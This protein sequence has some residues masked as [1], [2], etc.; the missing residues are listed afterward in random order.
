MWEW[1]PCPSDY[2]QCRKSTTKKHFAGRLPPTM[3]RPRFMAAEPIQFFNRTTGRVE[4]EQVYGEGFLRFTYGNPLGLL[5]LHALAKRA[6]FSRWY[7]WRMDRSISKSRVA[8]FIERYGLDAAEFAEPAESFR[9]FNEF[10]YRK[11]K[12]S[13]R[14][15]NPDSEVAV[16]P[17]DGRHL[18]L[19][20]LS[21]TDGFYVKGQRLDLA[22]LLGDASLA[23]EFAGGSIV[24]SRLCPVDYHR[25]HFPVVGLAEAPRLINGFLYSVSP[26]ALRRNI[27]Y[28]CQNKRSL[29]VI[30][31]PEFGR[32]AT[33]EVGATNVG[34]WDY[35]FAP[36]PVTKGQEKGF[37]RFG[38]SLTITVFAQGRAR[39]ADDL[40]ANG[41]RQREVYAK[42]G[43]AMAT[44]AERNGN[45]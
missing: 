36:G 25:F 10:F 40:I 17:A 34:S 28:L 32:V 23:R 11:L 1:V 26:I 4:T 12:P 33:L 20:D 14:P 2:W 38:G 13:A 44:A 45:R 35:T 37:F 27:R 8:C 21:K 5:A 18:G 41:A 15:V 3:I 42:I 24:F 16:F 43:D 9:S 30:E 39:L 19:Q 22:E 6:L 29:S 7:G 31:S